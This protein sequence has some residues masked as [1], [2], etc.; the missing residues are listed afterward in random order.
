MNLIDLLILVLIAY[1]LFNGYKKGFILTAFGFTKNFI[2]FFLSYFYRETFKVF[3]IKTFATDQAIYELIYQKINTFL[4]KNGGNIIQNKKILNDLPLPLEIKER[5]IKAIEF[6][7]E[8]ASHEIANVIVDFSI[9][10]LSVIILYMVIGL[11]LRI[12]A[13]ALNIIAKLP[14][15]NSFNKLGGV[16]VSIGILYF[17]FII[18]SNVAMMLS[19]F[20]KEAWFLEMLMNSKFINII[21]SNPV[22]IKFV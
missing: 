10:V 15:I 12:I 3:L 13:K 22:F 18:I 6:G 2:A 8:N 17:K 19:T 9:S 5:I 4:L 20:I 1:E 14:I 16:G 7:I 21:I 11:I